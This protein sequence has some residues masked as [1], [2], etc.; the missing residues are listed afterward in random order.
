MTLKDEVSCTRI[1]LPCRSTIC[2]H[3][4]CFDAET[5]L[6]L[7]DQAPQWKCP[8]CNTKL[9]FSTLAI[10]G[11]FENILKNTPASVEQVIIEPNG[12]WRVKAAEATV[13]S[14]DKPKKA[15]YDKDS[16]EDLIQ[17]TK[18][19]TMRAP[20]VKAATPGGVAQF[21]PPDSSR[22]ASVTLRRSVSTAAPSLNGTSKRGNAVIDLTMSDDD[23]PP[24]PTKRP[25]FA[26]ISS[27]QGSAFPVVPRPIPVP[28]IDHG[29]LPNSY[30]GRSNVMPGAHVPYARA[31]ITPA[32]RPAY[33]DR[34]GSLPREQSGAPMGM[35]GGQ[36]IS[37]SPA[38]ESLGMFDPYRNLRSD[39]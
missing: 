27:R 23:E 6:H 4:Q 10:D 29:P 5:F 36:R 9:S 7:Q 37:Q 33:A 30:F 21:T 18:Q 13:I 17:V 34:V 19:T 26:P 15:S 16:D 31:S 38:E 39:G 3:N 14:D 20:P 11:Y 24:R 8:I 25:A 35:S 12:E 22:E 28:S 1:S 2:K 32:P